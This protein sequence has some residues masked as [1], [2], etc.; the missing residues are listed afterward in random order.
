MAHIDFWPSPRAGGECANSGRSGGRGITRLHWNEV[1][2]RRGHPPD[3][4][5][6]RGTRGD[7]LALAQRGAAPP[8]CL[9]RHGGMQVG[10]PKAVSVKA[11]AWLER[12]GDHVGARYPDLRGRLRLCRDPPCGSATVLREDRHPNGTKPVGVRSERSEDRAVSEGPRPST[13]FVLLSIF[14]HCEHAH[15][16]NI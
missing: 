2:G 5:A 16:V 15:R 8:S 14:E 13:Y 12:S 9:R 3:R 7:G 4:Q 1:E 10:R 6:Q 11:L